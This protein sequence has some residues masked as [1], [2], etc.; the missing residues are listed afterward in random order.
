MTLPNK[1][2]LLRILLIPVILACL[3]YEKINPGNHWLIGGFRVAALILVIIATITDYYDGKL[4]RQY[5]LITNLGKFLDPLAD[6][7]LVT[8]IFIVFVDLRLFPG[9]LV[10]IILFREF[11]VTGLRSIVATQG[12]VMSSERWGKHKTGWQLATII[13]AITFMAARDFSQAA[14]VWERPLARDWHA[15]IFFEYVLLALLLICVFFTLFSGVLYVWKY[16]HLL[17]EDPPR[18]SP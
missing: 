8:S 1:L 16:R 12:E 9:W 2:S 7:L 14:R 13:T 3:L 4:A 11:V 15:D 10:I 17:H 6:K 18:S 5:G